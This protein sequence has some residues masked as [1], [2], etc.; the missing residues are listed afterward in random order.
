[1]R[2]FLFVNSLSGRYDPYGVA[3][4]VK[5]LRA[6]GLQPELCEVNSPDDVRVH[7]QSI[8]SAEDT[9]LV[10][11]AAGDGT[12]NAV[13]NSLEPG[14]TVIAVLPMGTSNV[15]AAEIGLSSVED[16]V[17]RIIAGRTRSLPVGVLGLEHACYR[18]LLMAGI[19]VDGAIVRDVRPHEK[20]RLKQGAYAL[21]AIRYAMHWDRTFIDLNTPGGTLSCHS[22]VICAASRYG[23]NFVLAHESDLFHPE[24]TVVCMPKQRRRDYFRLAWDLFSGRVGGNRDLIR[25]KTGR[26]EILG[27]KPIQIDGDFI[28]YSPATIEI[29]PD[30]SRIIV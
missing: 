20:R 2:S 24:F 29:L 9:P 18:F 30:F 26:V 14:R 23:G 11:I 7:G 28:G 10:I 13:I 16:G 6:A 15:L 3:A 17:Q 8:N 5:R 12:V 25:I 1:M 22:A 19:G 21:S 27:V 4:I